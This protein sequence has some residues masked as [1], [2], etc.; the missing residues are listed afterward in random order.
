VPEDEVVTPT[1]RHFDTD[2]QTPMEYDIQTR[3]WTCPTCE[4]NTRDH[5]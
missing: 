2:C 3:L 4:E 1:I 5:H